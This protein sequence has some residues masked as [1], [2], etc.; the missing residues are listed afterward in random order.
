MFTF[1]IV[2]FLEQFYTKAYQSSRS[3]CRDIE[4]N[5]KFCLYPNVSRKCE[6]YKYSKLDQIYIITFSSCLRFRDKFLLRTAGIYGEKISY[7]Q[8]ANSRVFCIQCTHLNVNTRKCEQMEDVN[9]IF[10]LFNLKILSV[11]KI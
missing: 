10:E 9:C 7:F 5:H 4:K 11:Y 8:L 1:S 2:K 6:H 3:K